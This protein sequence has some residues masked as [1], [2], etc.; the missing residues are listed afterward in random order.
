MAIFT[1][2]PQRYYNNIGSY[3]PVLVI[4]NGDTVITSTIDA[5]GWD[6][7][8]ESAAPRGNPMTGPF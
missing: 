4:S 8:G 6:H 5:R 7:T 1:F 2:Q 3:E